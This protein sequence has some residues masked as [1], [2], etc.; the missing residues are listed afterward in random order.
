[1]AL[2][3]AK[4]DDAGTAPA[5]IEVAITGTNADEFTVIPFGSCEMSP[6][7]APGDV[8]VMRV[9]FTPTG[10]GERTA[11]LQ[12]GG[13]QIPLAG[14]AIMPSGLTA[15]ITNLH[16]SSGALATP[17]YADGLIVNHGSTTASVGTIAATGDGM[18]F[19]AESTCNAPLSPGAACSFKISAGQAI[20]GC[21][22]GTFTIPSTAND[23]QIPVVSRYF[24]AV[25][26]RV[27]GGRIV[28]AP[29]GIDCSDQSGPSCEHIF[30]E[31][32]V[33]LTA[34][35][36]DGNHFNGWTP[37]RCGTEPTCTI[38]TVSYT[39]EGLLTP[40]G[41]MAYFAS[42]D[43][44]AINIT[45]VGGGT[46]YIHPLGCTGSCTRWVGYG[47][48]AVLRAIPASRF[49]GWQG[50]CTGTDV[51]CDLG[52]VV[53]GRDVAFLIE[54]EERE[55]YNHADLTE[56]AIDT[57]TFAVD[58]DLLL[59]GGGWVY[60]H[61]IDGAQRWMRYVVAPGS[62][63]RVISIKSLADAAYVLYGD[64]PSQLI[65]LDSAGAIVWR[66][67]LEAT[68]GSSSALAVTPDGRLAVIDRDSVV[69]YTTAGDVSWTQAVPGAT[70]VAVSS[71]GIVAVASGTGTVARF[72]AVGTPLTSWSLPG[73]VQY[74]QLAFDPQ[75]GLV[76]HNAYWGYATRLE[77]STGAQ[78]FMIALEASLNVRN[79]LAITSSG[80]YL[81]AR[82][83]KTPTILGA[84]IE[85]RDATGAVTWSLDKAGKH[86]A[87][88]NATPV[89]LGDVACD[90]ANHCA[91]FGISRGGWVQVF[92]MP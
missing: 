83:H 58:G 64:L 79:G 61:A 15:T 78:T 50:A 55:L 5:T 28:S 14:M 17:D 86:P 39:P 75:G 53:A 8:C 19:D 52:P 49:L 12:I 16:V 3:V 56:F 2:V 92:T 20:R 10:P 26:V 76:V 48:D 57:G 45:F 59:A 47:T 11:T 38:P 81:L 69:V 36:F 34:E 87:D 37:T 33:T 31:D 77:P 42:P 70:A 66:R 89:I 60:R 41:A 46:G 85:T 4:R 91:V 1:M 90:G 22:S 62:R 13:T 6:S 63:G 24:A 88:T 71:T 82:S 35:P 72:D 25:S 44:Y 7:L 54:R 80:E 32:T 29:P 43:A 73:S 68:G 23:V 27:N 65:K 40:T 21:A 84:I 74:V 67:S 51:I 18:F 9:G 30:T